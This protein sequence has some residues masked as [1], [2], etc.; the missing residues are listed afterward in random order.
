MTVT[1][2]LTAFPHAKHRIERALVYAASRLTPRKKSIQVE[3]SEDD[4]Q[5][6]T[7]KFWMPGKAYDKVVDDTAEEVQEAC[8]EFFEDIDIYVEE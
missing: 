5:S 3:F 2:E 1:V 6:I 4:D 8:L 7:L